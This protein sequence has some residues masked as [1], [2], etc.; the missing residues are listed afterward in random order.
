MTYL[1]RLEATQRGYVEYIK[2]APKQRMSNR[3]DTNRIRETLDQYDRV[4]DLIKEIK[5]KEKEIE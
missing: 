5:I 3:L 4:S 2:S 1:Q